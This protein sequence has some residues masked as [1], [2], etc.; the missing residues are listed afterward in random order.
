MSI[1]LS[2]GAVCRLIEARRGLFSRNA[3]LVVLLCVLLD[4]LLKR[5]VGCII[6]VRG[7]LFFRCRAR[8]A[9]YAVEIP[10]LKLNPFKD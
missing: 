4:V 10:R 6:E 5:A 2:K 9:A 7:G 8:G 3:L 1:A